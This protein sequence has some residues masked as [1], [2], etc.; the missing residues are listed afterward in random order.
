VSSRD[1]L[2]WLLANAMLSGCTAAAEPETDA[3]PL[4][5]TVTTVV[6][7]GRQGFD[8]DGNPA[9][10]SWLNQP[11]EVAFDAENNLYIVDWNNHRLRELSAGVLQTKVGTQLPGDWPP[12]VAADAELDA[13]ALSLNHPLD[14]AFDDDGRAVVA[15]WHNH[16]LLEL[17]ADMA[18]VRRL[19]G[20]N[21][22]GYAGDDGESLQALLN[23]P[24]SVVIDASGALLVSDQ[25][26][27]VIRRLAP[28]T[29][30]TVVGVKGSSSYVG[31]D[32]LA[33]AAGLGLCPYNEAG[34]SDNPPP[35]GALALDTDGNLYIADTYNHCVRRVRAGSDGLIGVGEAEE[36]LIETVA[37]EC[38]TAGF[39]PEASADSLRLDTPRDVE[40]H[41]GKLYIADT[42]NHVIWRMDLE[43]REVERVVGTGSEGDAVEGAAAL[44]AT[45]HEP[46]G[47]GFD[48]AD[49]LYIADTLNQRIRV[50]WKASE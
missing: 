39:E 13:S 36:E 43:T 10:K 4:P 29:I 42:G 49:D 12:D 9:R 1:V 15:A 41:Q 40:I 32:E 7:T 18:S 26:N 19:A 25:R 16:K 45:L 28:E 44:E 2:L 24:A 17:D 47:I 33:A 38:G 37:G 30:S 50:L 22:P 20:G 27:N 8:G 46:Y 48:H 35:G 11:T 21:R 6:G 14:L 5:G 23:F 34:G 31:D 3:I